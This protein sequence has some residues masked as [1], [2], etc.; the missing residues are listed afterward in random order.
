MAE[1]LTCT[2]AFC[3]SH[4]TDSD[5]TET[6]NAET[7]ETPAAGDEACVNMSRNDEGTLICVN[8]PRRGLI[9]EI[10]QYGLDEGEA[11]A[12]G[13]LEQIRR[14]RSAQLSSGAADGSS[15]SGMQVARGRS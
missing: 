4:E 5:G 6:C 9:Y 10:G 11:I 12:L 2:T 13:M 7:I 3:I 14:A 1:T 15:A 8:D